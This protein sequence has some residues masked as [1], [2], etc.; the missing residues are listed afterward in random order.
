MRLTVAEWQAMPEIVLPWTGQDTGF[1]LTALNG[2][3]SECG[4]PLSRLRGELYEAFG[5]IEVKMGGVC[6]VC[7][8]LVLCRSRVN[9]KTSS[10]F[11]E[12]NGK[13]QAYRMVTKNQKWQ[14]R[15]TRFFMPVMTIVSPLIIVVCLVA[16]PTKWTWLCW[17]MMLG[18]IVLM[19][20]IAGKPR[21]GE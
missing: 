4:T 3:C 14:M 8:H 20:V 12:R 11:L 2:Y 7:K 6:P 17:G 19:S 1:T 18:L 21:K 16:K 15:S 9:P 13:W 10:F 5:V